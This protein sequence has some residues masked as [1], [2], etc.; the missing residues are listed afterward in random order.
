LGYSDYD[1]HMTK[2]SDTEL[3]NLCKGNPLRLCD[4]G[5]RVYFRSARYSRHMEYVLAV[6]ADEFGFNHAVAAYELYRDDDE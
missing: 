6:V 1:N 2:L 5:E 4:T 3:L